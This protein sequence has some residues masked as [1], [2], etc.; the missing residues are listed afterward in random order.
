MR[1]G[2]ATAYSLLKD[3]AG[4]PTVRW[5]RGLNRHNLPLGATDIVAPRTTSYGK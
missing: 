1:D 2:G 4:L 3:Q 5:R